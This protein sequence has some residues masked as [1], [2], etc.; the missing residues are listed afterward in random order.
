[1]V[2]LL[3]PESLNR[4]A[5]VLPPGLR[6]VALLAGSFWTYSEVV[7]QVVDMVKRKDMHVPALGKVS[8]VNANYEVESARELLEVACQTAGVRCVEGVLYW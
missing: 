4:L 2:A 5:D 3:S 6:Q 1:M 8:V 7:E